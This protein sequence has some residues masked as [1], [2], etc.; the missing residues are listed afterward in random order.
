MQRL[1]NLHSSNHLNHL[2]YRRNLPHF[3]P[4]GAALFIT[5]RLYGTLP[6][7][8]GRDG[9]AF[10]AADRELERT[11]SGP[12]WLKQPR[13]AECVAETVRQGDRIRAVYDLVAFVVM[14]NHVHLLINPRAPAPKITQ[15]V[16]GVSAK[17]ANELLYRTGQ[18][19]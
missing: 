7:A 8:S 15:F 9:R 2:E 16:K 1:R 5:F 4:D 17:R 19:F 10:A 6:L 12:S 13:V 11:P 3:Q 18:P 14:P